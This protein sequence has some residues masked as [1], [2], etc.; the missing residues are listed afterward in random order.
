M[1]APT[2]VHTQETTVKPPAPVSYQA[3]LK[4]RC[5]TEWLAA[6]TLYRHLDEEEHRHRVWDMENCRTSAWFIRHI[7]TG[8][9]SV[10]ANHCSLRWCPLC[11]QARANYI[12]WSVS[13]WLPHADH[14]KFMTMT[15]KHSDEP[16]AEQVARLYS[17]F[18]K[19]RLKKAFTKYVNGGIW[20]FQLCRNTQRG[21]WHPHLHCIITGKYIPY[22]DLR[23]LWKEI[24]GDSDVV[25]IR[26]VR[27]PERVAAEVARYASRP[28]N[29]KNFRL[30]Y[31]IEMY[32][33]MHGKRLCG[34]WGLFTKVSL[35][36]QRNPK[37][38]E[39]EKIG[40]WQIVTEYAKTNLVAK[41]IIA[42]YETGNPL[43]AGCSLQNV[44]DF[45]DDFGD[46]ELHP[47][48]L[49]LP[50]PEKTLFGD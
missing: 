41:K 8:K 46:M 4:S 21:Q 15:L 16:L 33:A 35:S 47:T 34:K 42:A 20:F 22:K 39:W 3:R 18:R 27:D 2:L 38:S 36:V 44:D 30:K 50:P 43:E 1:D 6:L 31:G 25:D 24:T 23:K 11:A 40:S 26:I 48:T 28:A 10:V 9:V 13:D 37:M 49:D 45:I 14:P 5:S 19:L 12:R 17:S 7:E 32:N 29:L